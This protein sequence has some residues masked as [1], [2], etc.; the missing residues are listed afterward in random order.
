[1]RFQGDAQWQRDFFRL[2]EAR[3][4]QREH[5][6]AGHQCHDAGALDAAREELAL[7]DELQDEIDL[8]EHALRDLR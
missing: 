7:A 8:L 1:L 5:V 2:A 6:I 4:E 3:M